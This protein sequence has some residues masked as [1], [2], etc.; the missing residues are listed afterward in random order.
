LEV[1]VDLAA[2]NANLEANDYYGLTPIALA[3]SRRQWEVVKD[4]AALHA[5][6]EAKDN[7]GRT[8]IARAA[9]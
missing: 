3:A 5:N 9:E 7:S 6:L 2:R 8:P 4:F 1:V